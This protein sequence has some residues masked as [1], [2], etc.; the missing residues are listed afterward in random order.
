MS[1]QTAGGP[2]IYYKDLPGVYDPATGAV[3]LSTSPT[4]P[5]GSFN[6]TLHETGHGFDAAMGVLSGSRSFIDAY[7]LDH[8]SM[9]PYYN[10]PSNPESSRRE[11]LA[12]SFARYYGADP[13]FGT[14]ASQNWP[15]LYQFMAT[16]DAAMRAQWLRAHPNGH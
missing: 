7:N 4:H 2:T 11:A 5:Q 9:D 16:F 8:A 12:E 6:V 15:H 14:G 13:T 3:I 1:W 10:Q